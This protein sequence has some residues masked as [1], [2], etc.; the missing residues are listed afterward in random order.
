MVADGLGRRCFSRLSSRRRRRRRGGGGVDGG[1]DG[2]NG[3]GKGGSMTR[4]KKKARFSFC[5]SICR[6]SLCC[7]YLFPR[8]TKKDKQ[9]RSSRYCVA[10][11]IIYEQS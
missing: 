3:D 8:I 4:R 1:V 6:T 2:D 5:L 10:T 7:G 11:V 9:R